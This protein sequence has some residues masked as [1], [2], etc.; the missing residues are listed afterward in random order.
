MPAASST[1]R[2]RSSCGEVNGSSS[3][4]YAAVVGRDAAGIAAIHFAKLT[5]LLA[6]G[7]LTSKT[8]FRPLAKTEGPPPA[9]STN[10]YP[11]R[12]TTCEAAFVSEVEKGPNT[13]SA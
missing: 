1:L 9:P 7:R 6:T 5:R 4:A 3:V 11:Y 8:F 10:A 2:A 13:R 12:A